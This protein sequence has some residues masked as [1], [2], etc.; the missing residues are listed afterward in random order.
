M[1]VERRLHQ[2]WPVSLEA[3]VTNLA[4][5]ELPAT[6]KVVDVSESGMRMRLPL[7]LAPGAI[8]K[9]KVGDSS[10]FGEVIHSTQH[11]CACEI[12]VEIIRVLIGESDLSRLV[13][14]ILTEALPYTPGLRPVTHPPGAIKL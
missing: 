3:E 2:R 13:N 10:L 12:G 8:V 4:L 11:D 1:D 9:V 14:A 7:Q 6:A 5:P